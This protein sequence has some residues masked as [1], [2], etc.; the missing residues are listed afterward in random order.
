MGDKF[1][2]VLIASANSIFRNGINEKGN[3]T[4]KGLDNI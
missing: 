3:S 1:T 4:I 2:K